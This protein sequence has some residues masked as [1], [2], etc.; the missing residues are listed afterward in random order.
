MIIHIG[1]QMMVLDILGKVYNLL[2]H[3][4]YLLYL[5]HLLLKVRY[6]LNKQILMLKLNMHIYEHIKT[7][8][9]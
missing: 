9:N 5:L 8:K 7:N 3:L 6:I 4:L 1:Y 2:L